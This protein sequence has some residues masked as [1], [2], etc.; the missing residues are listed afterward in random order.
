MVIGGVSWGGENKKIGKFTIITQ[1]KMED[2]SIFCNVI[3]TFW[4]KK[5]TKVEKWKPSSPFKL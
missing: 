5:M 2:V 1:L 4:Q 3:E